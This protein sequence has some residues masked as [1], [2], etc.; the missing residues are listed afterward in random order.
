MKLK[1]VCLSLILAFALIG[2]NSLPQEEGK[3]WVEKQLTQCNEEWQEWVYT[4]YESELRDQGI[5]DFYSD[6]EITIFNIRR[7]RTNLGEA[8]EA[9]SCL[10]STKLFLQISNEDKD[11]FLAQGYK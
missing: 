10:S 2:C 11:Y 4:N 5:I 8:C 6:K 9:C 1:I 3:V 7:T